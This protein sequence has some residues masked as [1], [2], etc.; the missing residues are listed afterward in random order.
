MKAIILVYDCEGESFAKEISVNFVSISA[1][2]NNDI[3]NLLKK[4]MVIFKIK[5]MR[6]LI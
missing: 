3:Q 2:S 4:I 1:K 6:K 5:L